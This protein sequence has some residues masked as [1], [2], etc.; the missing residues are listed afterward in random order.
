MYQVHRCLPHRSDP[1]QQ[2]RRW[3]QVYLLLH[4]RIERRIKARSPARKQRSM[5]IW[6]RCMSGCMP[7]EPLFTTASGSG[8]HSHT[9]VTCLEPKRLGIP[10]GSQLSGTIQTITHQAC[11]ICRHPAKSALAKKKTLTYLQSRQRRHGHVFN[12]S[13]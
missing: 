10:Y 13:L 7:L 6:M 5:V 9:R 4:D 8:I 2:N 12:T 1:S 11:E 3:Q